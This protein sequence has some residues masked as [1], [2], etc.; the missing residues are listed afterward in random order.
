MISV[1][2]AIE[3]V[4]SHESHLLNVPVFD[5]WK[6][7]LSHILFKLSTFMNIYRYFLARYKASLE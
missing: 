5:G 7:L 1:K 6:M 4:W 3:K 2:S